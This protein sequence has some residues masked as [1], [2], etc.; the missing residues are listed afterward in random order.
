LLKF[1]VISNPPPMQEWTLYAKIHPPHLD[2]FLASQGG[3]FR[4]VRL[5]NGHT[6]LEGTTWYY[7]NMQPELYWKLWADQIIHRIHLRVLNHVKA[8]AEG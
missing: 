6:L 4:L 1:S 8:L 5:S 3:Q 7:H 2:R